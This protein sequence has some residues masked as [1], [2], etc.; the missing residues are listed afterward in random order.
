[1]KPTFDFIPEKPAQL[2]DL[3]MRVRPVITKNFH[4]L[5]DLVQGSQLLPFDDVYVEVTYDGNVLGQ[6][7]MT[8]SAPTRWNLLD[9][10]DILT[11]EISLCLKGK[12]DGHSKDDQGQTVTMC[13]IV[14]ML[15]ENVLVIDAITG[16]GQLLLGE[17]DRPLTLTVT[18][19]IYRWLL[20]NRN[21]F[22]KTRL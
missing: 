8:S 1:M 16:G 3:E 9:D 20:A 4:V 14:D 21:V 7:G 22:Y 13:A 5:P 19:P 11:H 2:F 17:N 6:L 15:I 10:K 12:Q 18:T